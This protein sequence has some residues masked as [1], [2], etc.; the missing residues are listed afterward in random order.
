M[1]EWIKEEEI[2]SMKNLEILKHLKDPY[3]S[4]YKE[5]SERDKSCIH[6]DKWHFLYIFMPYTC[7]ITYYQITVL[8]WI[9]ISSFS[10]CIWILGPQVLE[11]FGKERI[12]RYS[13]EEEEVCHTRKNFECEGQIWMNLT[14]P[15]LCPLLDPKFNQVPRMSPTPT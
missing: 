5:K 4:A 14:L 7:Q 8:I 13:M 9:R 1:L 15:L 11:L 3:C 2:S 10:S 6:K 12:S